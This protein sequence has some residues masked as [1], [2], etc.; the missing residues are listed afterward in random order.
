MTV[1]N[2]NVNQIPDTTTAHSHYCH[3]KVIVWSAVITGALVAFG[4]TFLL[5]IFDKALGIQVFSAA[6]SEEASVMV[7]GGFIASIIGVFASMFFAGW[8]AGN[9][10]K[11]HHFNNSYFAKYAFAR[12]Y[13]LLYG[14]LTWCLGL[15]IS[16]AFIMQMGGGVLGYDYYNVPASTALSVVSSTT[17]Q[18]ATEMT[19]GMPQKTAMTSVNDN[20]ATQQ[21]GMSL[22]LTFVLFF[23]GAVASSFGGYY[24][25]KP[26]G[27]ENITLVNPPLS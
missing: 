26:Y 3:Q 25:L 9:V 18:T 4:L 12:H 8:V 13:G 17:N 2:F 19:E 7:W 16:L 23:I 24:G 21:V 15:I 14:L 11:Y 6:S 1:Q 22:F 20:R 5:Q 10:A 27:V